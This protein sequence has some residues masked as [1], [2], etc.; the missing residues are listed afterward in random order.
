MINVRGRREGGRLLTEF[1]QGKITN[2]DYNDA[3]PS[4]SAD[5]GLNV[6]YRRIWV[7][8]SDLHSHYLD[9]HELS[10]DDI[11]LFQRCIDF[12]NTD[13]EYNGPSIGMHSP[14]ARIFKNL[15]GRDEEPIT[16]LGAATTEASGFFTPWWPFASAL[17]YEQAKRGPA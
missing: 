5:A 11:A 10:E 2:D 3:F 13:L 16:V 14:F 7:Y 1:F 17:E 6:V 9:R 12:L 4:G 8:Y 15:L